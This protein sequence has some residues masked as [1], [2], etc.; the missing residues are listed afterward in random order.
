MQLLSF[1]LLFAFSLSTK[2]VAPREVVSVPIVDVT[3]LL[4]YEESKEIN[5]DMKTTINAIDSALQSQGVFL[6]TAD[7]FKNPGYFQNFLKAAHILFQLPAE[8][9]ESVSIESNAHRR[10]VFLPLD[11]CAASSRF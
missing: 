5:H 4:Q 1:L 7:D 11:S 6:L 3:S 9:K 10:F 2:H 8:Q